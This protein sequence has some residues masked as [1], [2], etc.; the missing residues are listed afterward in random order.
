MMFSTKLR[1]EKK[2]TLI[3]IQLKLNERKNINRKTLLVIR[4]KTKF[5]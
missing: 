4:E 1:K 5:E 3:T 2:K